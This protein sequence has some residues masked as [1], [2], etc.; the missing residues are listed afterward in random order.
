[1]N[2]LY[3]ILFIFSVSIFTVSGQLS[4]FAGCDYS[5]GI[6]FIMEND[7][8]VWQHP[9]PDSNDIW[10]LP[11]GNIL[12]TTGKGVLEMTRQN[13]TVFQYTSDSHIFACQR[14]SN[15]NTFIGECTTGRM[16][17]VAPDGRIV[18]EVSIPPEGVTEG[19]FA[20]MRNARRL[21]NGNYLAAH[22]GDREVKEYD[23]QGRVVWRVEV[24]GGPHSLICLPNG[25]T[26]ISVADMTQDPKIIEVDKE[27]NCIWE[28]SN[29]HI[30]GSPLKFLGG[31][32]VFADGT[33]LFTNWTGHEKPKDKIHLFLVT[34][35]KEV[36]FMQKDHP[37]LQ[38]MS[39]VYTTGLPGA[40]NS[41]H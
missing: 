27:G 35:E 25:N 20:F 9:A 14:L 22:Y 11:N 21:A 23:S 12:F 24:P 3:S 39:S 13:D 8:I 10:L 38:T 36:L 6:V 40:E 31:L 4:S 1:M 33:V 29:S 41:F 30:A 2:Y 16:L 19:G 17:E 18:K 15:G 5:Q 7:E 28:F 34:K 37:G 26:M 32:Q